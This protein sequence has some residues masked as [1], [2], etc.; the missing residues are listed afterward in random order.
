M[1]IAKS[2]KKI[3]DAERAAVEKISERLVADFNRIEAKGLSE[4]ARELAKKQARESA[5]DDRARLRGSRVEQI[6]ALKAEKMTKLFGDADPAEKDRFFQ[7]VDKTAS[8]KKPEEIQAAYARAKKYGDWTT[9]KAAALRGLEVGEDSVVRDYSSLDE[10]FRAG[11]REYAE[12][13]A[14]LKQKGVNLLIDMTAGAVRTPQIVEMIE[15][16][17]GHYYDGK[18]AIPTR[19]VERVY[20]LEPPQEKPMFGDVSGGIREAEG[21][22]LTASREFIQAVTAEA[23]LR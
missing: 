17:G 13:V 3:L 4:T 5:A 16:D 15:K 6:E 12:I 14:T 7:A 2:I 18:R 10:N 21:G 11:H 1:T 20:G 8:L 22:R 19:R 9:A 23:E